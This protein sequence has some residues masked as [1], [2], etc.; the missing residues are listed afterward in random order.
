M[1]NSDVD[2][3]AVRHFCHKAEDKLETIPPGSIC[4]KHRVYTFSNTIIELIQKS[5][6]VL[7]II[8]DHSMCAD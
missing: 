2:D 4:N 3:F 1:V 6:Q 7:S 5:K 8:A